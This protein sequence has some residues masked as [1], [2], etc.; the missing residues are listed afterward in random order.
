MRV[1]AS[2]CDGLDTACLHSVAGLFQRLEL[3]ISYEPVTVGE[4]L[5]RLGRNAEAQTLRTQLEELAPRSPLA[6]TIAV[7]CVAV[8]S[9]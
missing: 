9:N 7:E 8:R 3:A 6:Q 2:V 1:A 4:V 5:C